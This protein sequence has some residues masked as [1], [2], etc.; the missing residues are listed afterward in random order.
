M[1][2]LDAF[3]DSSSSK[4]AVASGTKSRPAQDHPMEGQPAS[5]GLQV[6]LLEFFQG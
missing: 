4:E 3:W 1:Q 2:E 6:A 5:A